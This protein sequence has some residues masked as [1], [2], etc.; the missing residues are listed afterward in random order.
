MKNDLTASSLKNDLKATDK[1]FTI[2]LFMFIG[3]MLPIAA[4][5]KNRDQLYTYFYVAGLG[6]GIFFII[7]RLIKSKEKIAIN[8]N[9]KCSNCGKVPPAYFMEKAFKNKKICIIC[10]KEKSITNGSN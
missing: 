1:K 3:L 5:I 6:L 2:I 8:Y 4:L 9:L 10:K 7:V